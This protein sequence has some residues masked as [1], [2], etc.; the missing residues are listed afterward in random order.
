MP[1][2]IAAQ[3]LDKAPN[4]SHAVGDLQRL[5][6]S[7][8]EAR[9]YLSLLQVHPATAYE[10]SKHTGLPR[11]NTY[12][13]LGNLTRKRAV[14]PVS[15]HPVRYAPVAPEVLLDRLAT[16]VSDTCLRLKDSLQSMEPVEE[17]DVVWSIEGQE[18]IERKIEELIQGA[19][20]HIW[21][22]ASTEVL[23]RHARQLKL[24]AARGVSLVFVVFGDDVDFLRFGRQ[25]KVYLHEGNGLRMGGADNLFTIAS[26]YRIALTATVAENLTGAY[27]TNSSVV[28]MAESLIRHDIYMAEIMTEY[29]KEIEQRF[30]VGLFKLRRQ[31]FSPEQLQL[32]ETNLVKTSAQTA[33][34]SGEAAVV[35]S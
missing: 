22:K 26:D 6:F 1:K 13:A 10:I 25:S 30:G 18:E 12:G 24:A 28:R 3:S 16:E 19:K 15:E 20:Q 9:T 17:S 14:Q 23:Q 11:A 27:T 7:D 33:S 29:G 8:Y 35:A 21:I 34:R 31:M 4:L 5:G 32:L 2:S